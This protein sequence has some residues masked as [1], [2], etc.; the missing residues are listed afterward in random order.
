[1]ILLT[2]HINSELIKCKSFDNLIRVNDFNK[3]K[4]FVFLKKIKKKKEGKIYQI[5]IKKKK[6]G[7]K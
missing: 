1:L 2:L 3:N 4:L 6:K 5:K 7:K